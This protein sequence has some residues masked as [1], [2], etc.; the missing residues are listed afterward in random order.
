MIEFLHTCW[1]QEGTRIA[2]EQTLRA[3]FLPMLTTLV[4]RGSHAA[5]ELNARVIGSIGG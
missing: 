3:L 2:R 4:A 5:I 1:K